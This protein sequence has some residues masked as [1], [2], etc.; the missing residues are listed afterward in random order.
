MSESRPWVHVALWCCGWFLSFL[1]Y[2]S[3]NFLFDFS[4]LS[5]RYVIHLQFRTVTFLCDEHVLV[6]P[7]LILGNRGLSGRAKIHLCVYTC[8][9]LVNQNTPSQRSVETVLLFLISCGDNK[10]EML[11]FGTGGACSLCHA[12][13]N[14]IWLSFFLRLEGRCHFS[15]RQHAKAWDTIAH[16]LRW[17]MHWIH[18]LSLLMLVLFLL[19]CRN[20]HRSFDKGVGMLFFCC[21]VVGLYNFWHY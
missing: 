14:E 8:V 11:L 2:I 15:V 3:A 13:P 1:D 12:K 5:K 21:G 4:H 9:G 20:W 10:K 18:V 16:D 19:L 6:F 7:N 17:I